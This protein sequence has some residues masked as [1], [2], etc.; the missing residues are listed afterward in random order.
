VNPI[1]ERDVSKSPL[2]KREVEIVEMS[3]PENHE[4][5]VRCS[6]ADS[7]CD[8][9]SA[10]LQMSIPSRSAA[11]RAMAD[12]DLRGEQSIRSREPRTR[13]RDPFQ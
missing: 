2:E 10:R 9:F 1:D 5:I 8:K 12:G 6:G 11:F 13:R 3:A 7:V 4:V